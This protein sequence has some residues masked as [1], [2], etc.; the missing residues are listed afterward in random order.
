MK[1]IDA[2][3]S[4]YPVELMPGVTI[5]AEL[6]DFEMLRSFADKK[7]SRGKKADKKEDMLILICL[8][9]RGKICVEAVKTGEKQISAAET[10][11]LSDSIE[12]ACSRDCGDTVNGNF[13]HTCLVIDVEPTLQYL[14]TV[15]EEAAGKLEKV[16]NLLIRVR[17]VK[18]LSS[19]SRAS[20]IMA[21]ICQ[22]MEKRETGYLKI[23]TMELILILDGDMEEEEKGKEH[24]P[25]PTQIH[26]AERTAQ[27]ISERVGSRV[28]AAELSQRFNISPGYLQSSFKKVYGLTIYAYMLDINMRSAAERLVETELSILEIASEYG[29]DNASKFA[30]AFR[31]VMGTT[32]ARYRKRYRSSHRN[33]YRNT[34]VVSEYFSSVSE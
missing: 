33:R 17:R 18:S 23:K 34:A 12:R 31:R 5:F 24:S 32:P 3:T 4:R 2:D 14:N 22:S 26:A 29:Y 20:R 16:T 11:T 27:Y 10:E 7:L 21:E 19:Q 8:C 13:R 25:S 30:A 28:S 6:K 9:D 15:I 1:P